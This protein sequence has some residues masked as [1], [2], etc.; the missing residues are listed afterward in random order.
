MYVAGMESKKYNVIIQSFLAMNISLKNS[1]QLLQSFPFAPQKY[2]PHNE[3]YDD[4][5]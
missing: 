5:K 2:L 3:S 1:L 4:G